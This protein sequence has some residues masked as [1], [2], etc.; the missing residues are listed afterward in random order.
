MGASVYRKNEDYPKDYRTPEN[1]I[2]LEDGDI[3][4][5]YFIGGFVLGDMDEIDNGK[6]DL[7]YIS[8]TSQEFIDE[9]YLK[10]KYYLSEDNISDE[11]IEEISDKGYISDIAERNNLISKM[12]NVKKTSLDG[13]FATREVIEISTGSDCVLLSVNYFDRDGDIIKEDDYKF[14]LN[15]PIVKHEDDT[16]IAKL[17]K[18]ELGNFYVTIDSLYQEDYYTSLYNVS[19]FP[20][21]F[22]VFAE[23]GDLDLFIM[24]L[25]S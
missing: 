25:R 19:D 3:I 12:K 18:D 11:I 7:E 17:Y 15:E 8:T 5:E 16:F 13:V 21:E 6:L 4:K 2:F 20:E 22:Q 9:D 14:L 1:I 10:G 24:N 23:N